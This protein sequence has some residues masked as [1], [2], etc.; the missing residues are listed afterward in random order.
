MFEKLQKKW[1]VSGV[2]LVFIIATFA[3]GGSL[4]GF[5]GKKIMNFLSIGEDW[6]WGILYI[7]IITILWPASV[8]LV[9]IF[10]GQF[11]FFK[12]YIQKIGQKFSGKNRTNSI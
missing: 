7:L 6:I 11:R 10:T 12:K 8:L 9:S 5:A 1:K 4:A 3:I 2:R